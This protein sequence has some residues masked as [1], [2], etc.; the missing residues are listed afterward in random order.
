[1]YRSLFGIPKIFESL[2]F[3]A[4]F[5]VKVPEYKTHFYLH[6][7]QDL[8]RETDLFWRG[9]FT[10]YESLSLRIWAHVCSKG[11]AVLDVGANSG[12]FTM[13][14]RSV[15]SDL[16]VVAFEPIPYNLNILKANARINNYRI[17]LVE[18]AISNQS[19]A[20]QMFV[21]PDTVNY[22]TSVNL[23]REQE[24][25]TEEMTIPTISIDEYAAT[26][27]INRIDIIKLDVEGHEPQ[28]LQGALTIIER[29]LPSM[30]VEVLSDEDGKQI[31]ELL[32]DFPYQYFQLDENYVKPEE[33][34]AKKVNRLFYNHGQNFLI[35][36]AEMADELTQKGLLRP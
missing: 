35:C 17:D 32:S 15:H 9:V 27:G 11:E 20:C 6:N 29:D 18:K 31:Q 24:S 21:K 30:L 2:R 28:A 14:A 7:Q 36:T 23:N 5:R 8:H 1:M 25:E 22:M 4:P 19:G 13:L 26:A 34:C 33:S 16:T 10:G 12:I 3:K